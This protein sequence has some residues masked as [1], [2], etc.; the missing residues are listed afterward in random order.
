MNHKTLL[1]V[2]LLSAAVN[3]S[4]LDLGNDVVLHGSV[5]SDILLPEE[6]ARIGTGSYSEDVLT[7]TYADLKL[8]SRYVDAGLRFEYLEHPMPGFE[9][10]F[11]GWGV[12]NIYVK[13]KYKGLELTAGDFY[14]QFGSGF[15]LRTYEERT[16]GIDNS[17]RGGRLKVNSLKGLRFTALGG[18]QRRYWDWSKDS[19]IYGADAEFDIETYSSALRDKN[20]NWSVGASYVLKNEDDE[21]ILIPGSN[22]RLN[23]PN[24]VSAFD[25]RSHFSKNNFGLMG[26]FAWKSQ[27]PS[28]DNSYTYRNGNAVMLS[29]SYS[30]TG[31]SGLVQA[32]RSENMAYR[33]QR[34]M[35]GT[36]AFLNNM[37]A[38]AY[39]HTYAL[40]ALYPYAT[41]AADG[42]WAFQ[43]MFTYNFKRKT[44]LGGK[45]GTKLHL[46][47]SYVRGLDKEATPYI[48][49]LSTAY[50]SNGDKAS[51]FGFG[52]INYQDI[53]VQLD[54]RVTRDFSFVFM[55]MNQR[56]NK[57]VVEGHGGMINSNIF[58]Y[59]GKYKLSK[60][61][62]LRTELQYL[63]TKQDDGDWCYGLAELSVAPYLMFT[64]SDMWNNGKTDTHY[65]MGCI[66][67]NYKANRLM[68]SYGRTRAGYNCSGGVCRYV[69]ATR[70]FQVSYSYNF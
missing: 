31:F 44:A 57:T 27:D 30:K 47:M 7:N 53:N 48:E 32:K 8:L 24:N 26:E 65:Y 20:V 59:D 16:L 43:G 40:P 19:R 36:S 2:G 23:L 52:D 29:A 1:A 51:F 5:K 35:T 4:A 45:Y 56:Y 28:F 62:T 70:G 49:G 68:L 69:P 10:D 66:T 3:A 38:F 9:N 25:V 64:I 18:V 14:E 13:G 34:S 55:Y 37:P 17:I 21:N 46:N 41:Q 42:E 33:S 50:G 6:D 67:G 63:T 11:K 54:K 12:P 22:Y 39:Q 60:K 61:L 58:V 15:I